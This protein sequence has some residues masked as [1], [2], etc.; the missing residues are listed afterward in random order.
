MLKRSRVFEIHNP[1]A[2]HHISKVCLRAAW[3]S[4]TRF[5]ILNLVFPSVILFYFS[6]YFSFL[7]CTDAHTH[8]HKGLRPK[9]S[10]QILHIPFHSLF[11]SL[12]FLSLSF[13]SLFLS[14]FL[15]LI[16]LCDYTWIFLIPTPSLKISLISQN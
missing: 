5:S 6:P 9:N 14:F 10:I 7:S 3:Q 1:G 15:T 8:T 16:Q 4:N 11:L 13:L 2:V 12:S